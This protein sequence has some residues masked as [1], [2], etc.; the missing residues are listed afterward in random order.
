MAF[1]QSTRRRGAVSSHTLTPGVLFQ[2]VRE[3]QAASRAE[4][5][6]TTGLAR[7]TVSQRVDALLGLGLLVEQG[8]GTSTGGR[9]PTQLAFDA[10][11]GVVLCADLGATHCRLAISDLECTVLASVPA[12]M[13]IAR[14]PDVVLPWLQERFAELLDETGRAHADVRGIGIG[15][16]GPVE[17]AAGRA[18]SPP[19]MP[20][21]DGVPLPPAFADR[22]P[23]VPVL[24]DNDVNVMALGEYWTSWRQSIDDLLFVKVATGIGCGIVAG[25]TIHRGAD[26]TAGDLG[27]VQI[28]DAGDALCRCGNRG[29]VEAVASG[30]AVARELSSIGIEA[31]D[32]RDVVRLVRAGN[33]Q[34]L[35]LVRQAGRLVGE[36]LAGAVNFFNPSVIVLGGDLAH[37]HEQFFAGVREVVYRRSTALATQHLELARSRLD[38]TAG[39]IGC[40]VTIV[41]QILSP[42]AIDAELAELAR[43]AAD[44]ATA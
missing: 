33:P 17:F 25:G 22:F 19:I 29:C 39:V 13:E 36:V 5:A 40:A 15:V 18:V 2:L 44:E 4:L 27:H 1:R 43:P 24:V 35:T 31:H 30:G 21:W 8:G 11:S 6:R 38:D 41:E 9:P 32:S 26:G 10:G 3:G 28:P 14:G 7:S 12:E 20:G 37:A 16:P 42:A 23:G 34:A